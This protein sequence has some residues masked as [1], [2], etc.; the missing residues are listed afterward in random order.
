MNDNAFANSDYELVYVRL[1]QWLA[2]CKIE[3]FAV[4]VNNLLRVDL[5]AYW[6]KK[7]GRY[8]SFLRQILYNADKAMTA[9]HAL[10]FR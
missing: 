10:L 5:L 3:V 8:C 6:Q 4:P 7:G 1:M 9:V 2:Q